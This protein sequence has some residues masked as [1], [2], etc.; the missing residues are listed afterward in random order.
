MGLK[1][2]PSLL[3]SHCTV[4]AALPLAAAVKL[5]VLPAMTVWLAGF[6]VTAGAHWTTSVA[7]EV[8]AEPAMF[9]KTASYS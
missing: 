5:A 6:M 1:F 3:I 9:V 2:T 4:G 8:V 7:G